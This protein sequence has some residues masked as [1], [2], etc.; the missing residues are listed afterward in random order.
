MR[1]NWLTRLSHWVPPLLGIV[2]L[3]AS[4]WTIW[5]Q[6]QAYSPQ[7]LLNSLT[8]I[9]APAIGL[10]ILLT[11][12][13]YGVMT[14]YDTL[15]VRYVKRPIRYR[16]TALVAV[17]TN[18][19]SNTIGFALLSGSAIRYRFY[20]A[21]NF[22][23]IDVAHIIA[24]CNLSFWLGL[25]TVGGVVFLWQSVSVPA[26]LHLPF[27]SVQPIGA[28]FAAIIAAYVIWNA[29][30]Q[31]SLRIGDWEL[32]HLTIQLCLA[33]L[34]VAALDWILATLVFY[35]LLS[36][37][38]SF[39]SFFAVYLFAQLASIISNVP[40]GLGVFETVMLLLLSTSIASV[41]LF[42]VLLAY[43]CIY[44]FL[45][46]GLATLL[47]GFYELRQRWRRV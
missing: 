15:A 36:T 28:L 43:R 26:V 27:A 29:V 2:L 16:R 30:S 37:T 13:N 5:R 7:E 21:W 42:G 17:I 3:V 40:G 22:S 6:L 24:F 10:A 33:Q 8:A 4:G 44:Y 25:F 32:P 20:L 18:A 19:I 1:Q 45:P 23:A 12:V 11:F 31:R 41:Q 14:G 34:V 38:I 9:P 47:L 39:A 46:L 35:V